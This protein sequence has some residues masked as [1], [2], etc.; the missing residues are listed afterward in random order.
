MTRLAMNGVL[1]AGVLTLA[2][3]SA[4]AA[5]QCAAP[6]GPPPQSDRP[7]PPTRPVR[8]ACVDPRTHMSSCRANVLKTYNAEVDAYNARLK[9]YQTQLAGYMAALDSYTKSA[10]AYANCEVDTVNS[11]N[12][13]L[14]ADN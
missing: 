6:L 13:A 3:Q 8:P 2:A 10:L 14:N 7:V 1:L 12:N 5:E 9:Q 4:V 11:Q